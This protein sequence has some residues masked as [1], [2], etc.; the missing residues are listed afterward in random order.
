MCKLTLRMV[1][2]TSIPNIFGLLHVAYTI[3]CFVTISFK[4]GIS[5]LKSLMQTHSKDQLVDEKNIAKP[6]ESHVDYCFSTI[7]IVCM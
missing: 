5:Y 4:I 1:G 2:S 3:I 6:N 7:I